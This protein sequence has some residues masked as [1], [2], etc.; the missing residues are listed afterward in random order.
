[1]N[2]RP[3]RALAKPA[4]DDDLLDRARTAANPSPERD[5]DTISV[6]VTLRAADPSA[7][8]DL[9]RRQRDALVRLLRQAVEADR[10]G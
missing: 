8:L 7:A 4:L 10:L 5:T 3:R 2:P 9:R 1:M 6:E